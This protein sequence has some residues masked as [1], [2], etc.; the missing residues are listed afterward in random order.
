MSSCGL[1]LGKHWRF[2]RTG[3]RSVGIGLLKNTHNFAFQFREFHGE[4]HTLRM[5]DQVAS[6][7]QQIDVVPQNFAHPPLD[8]IAI[9]RFAEHFADS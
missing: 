5:Q 1:C 4:H 7:G 3:A 8:P 6:R 2:S 9:V